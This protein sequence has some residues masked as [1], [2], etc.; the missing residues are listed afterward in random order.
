MVIEEVN[1]RHTLTDNEMAALARSQ[2]QAFGQ[3]KAL[4]DE[5]SAIKK[6]YAG[7]LALSN[8]NISNIASRVNTGWEMRSVRCL[9]LDERPEGYRLTVRTDTGHIA[10]WRKLNP[11][12]RQL[13][14]N[15]EAPREFAFTALFPVDDA[16]WNDVD[17]YQCPLYADE[18]EE[19]RNVP[20]IE[21]IPFVRRRVIEDGKTDPK[22]KK[23][24]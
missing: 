17:V 8:A 20:F 12:E 13:K 15:P 2:S 6:D 14:L 11:E 18:A 21:L 4:E 19:L 16:T 22:G 1:L 3:L 7:R 10:I 9:L 5:I 23:R 24:Q